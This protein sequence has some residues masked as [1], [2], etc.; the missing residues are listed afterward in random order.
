MRSTSG[1]LA[2]ARNGSAENGLAAADASTAPWTSSAHG[3]TRSRLPI[4][5]C[6]IRLA[7]L[8]WTTRPSSNGLRS[9]PATG[10][11]TTRTRAF[12]RGEAGR[13]RFTMQELRLVSDMALDRIAVEGNTDSAAVADRIRQGVAA[14]GAARPDTGVAWP[15]QELWELRQV[16]QATDRKTHGSA[17]G[18]SQA[19]SRPGK[20]S[21]GVGAHA[22]LQPADAGRGREMR[23][24]LLLLQYP[25][26]LSWQ[27]G[28]VRRRV[29]GQARR[30]ANWI[31]TRSITSVPG[32]P[33]IP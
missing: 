13:F 5:P 26:V 27:R 32:S 14:R 12:L 18:E 31:R 29:R 23:L 33:R 24:R 6:R 8:P 15:R 2:R 4:I 11:S 1:F 19:T 9:R 7:R 16:G 10:C 17:G 28:D 22:V 30:I 3:K 25:V 20:V 21:G